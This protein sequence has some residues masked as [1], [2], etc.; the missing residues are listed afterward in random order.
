MGSLRQ[1]VPPPLLHSIH[2]QH[3]HPSWLF[4]LSLFD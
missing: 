2:S 1:M 3:S 4:F